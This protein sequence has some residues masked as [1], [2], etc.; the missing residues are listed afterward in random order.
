MKLFV[1]F[2]ILFV[3]ISISFS[4]EI[5]GKVRSISPDSKRLIIYTEYNKEVAVLDAD[6]FSKL[7]E[8]ERNK[9]FNS[10]VFVSDSSFLFF[11]DSMKCKVINYNTGILETVNKLSGIRSSYLHYDND[12]NILYIFASGI[13][14]ENSIIYLY[15]FTYNTLEEIT[16]KQNLHWT[17]DIDVFSKYIVYANIEGFLSK[18]DLQKKQIIHIR[19]SD[20]NKI[21]MNEGTLNLFNN[22][23]SI[24]ISF[25]TS[26]KIAVFEIQTKKLKYLNEYDGYG[27]PRLAPNGKDLYADDSSY[28]PFYSKKFKLNAF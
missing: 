25:Y 9:S 28:P 18:F 22:N 21:D 24:L 26:K 4:Q 27:F 8:R 16:I 6:T 3:F 7:F 10:C 15:S 5:E 1:R 23:K 12:L 13:H 2:I 17:F 11:D 14:S 20:E 19:D